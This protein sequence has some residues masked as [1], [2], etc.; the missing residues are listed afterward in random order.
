LLP[1][2]E[3]PFEASSALPALCEHA[4]PV[5]FYG[6]FFASPVPPAVPFEVL[7]EIPALP[8]VHFEVLSASPVPFENRSGV[9]SSLPAPAEIPAPIGMLPGM[10]FL[11]PV[12]GYPPVLSGTFSVSSAAPVGPAVFSAAR[13]QPDK[14]SS[15][16]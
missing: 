9:L 4:L 7:S 16:C 13:N 3:K 11:P 12:P 15:L 5:E 6:T 10:F 8:A 1:E 14:D 2:S